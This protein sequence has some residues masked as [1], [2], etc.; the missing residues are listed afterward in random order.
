MEDDFRPIPS[1][2]GYRVSKLGEVQSCWSRRGRLSLMPDAWHSLKQINRLGYLTVNLAEGGKKSD[3]RL[4]RLVLEAFVGPCLPGMVACH[5]DGDRSNSDLANLRWGTPKANSDDMLRHGTRATGARCRA[6]KLSEGEVIEIRRLRTEG[7]SFGD[8]AARFN[9]TTYNI[10][11]IVYRR[12]WRH[13]ADVW[14]GSG[15]GTFISFDG[16]YQRQGGLS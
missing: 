1:F 16:C 11:A 2:P 15:Q 14:G 4:H 12:S 9:V 10:K 6:T 5:N 7:V 8:L 13:L 3:R